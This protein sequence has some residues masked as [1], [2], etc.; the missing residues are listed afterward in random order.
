MKTQYYVRIALEYTW[1]VIE[2]RS[3]IQ[4]YI[5]KYVN[6]YNYVLRLENCNHHEHN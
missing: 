6:P 2:S 1:N 3:C 4:F 5:P